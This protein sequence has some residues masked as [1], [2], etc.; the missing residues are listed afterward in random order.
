QDDNKTSFHVVD[1]GVGYAFDKNVKLTGDYAW[2]PSQN[3]KEN[4]ANN[5]YSIQL[6]Y[7]GADAADAGSWGT[8]VAYRQMAPFAAFATDYSFKKG[9]AEF[10]TLKGWE[11]GADYTFAKNIIATAKYF[12]GK[13]TA[14]TTKDKVTGMWTRVDFL[15]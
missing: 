9:V 5:A 11:I 14:L 12:N 13:D 7:K 1:L 10:N 2:G 8:Y 15:F 4:A 6:N 3:L